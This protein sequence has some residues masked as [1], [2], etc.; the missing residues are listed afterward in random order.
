MV[1]Q[2]S[3]I[4]EGITDAAAFWFVFHDLTQALHWERARPARK[5]MLVSTACGSRWVIG[6]RSTHPLPQMVLT[7]PGGRDARGP[8][9][10]I[11]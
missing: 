7:R 9:K 8:S 3:M 6:K 2:S 5:W 11:E 10:E 1:A 4:C